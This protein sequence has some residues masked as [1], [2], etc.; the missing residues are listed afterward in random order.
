MVTSFKYLGQGLM[1]GY[2]DWPAVVGNLKKVRKSW[3]LLTRILG[4]EGANPR[5]LGV[6]FKA[7]LQVVLIFRSETW[8]MNPH[9]G[10]ALVSFQHGVARRITGMHLKIQEEGGWEYPPL[11]AAMEEAGLEEIRS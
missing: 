6:F 10:R 3:D 11:E 1:A 2:D 9:I 4:Q 7:V 5:V 8:V